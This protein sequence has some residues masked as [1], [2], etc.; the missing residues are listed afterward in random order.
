MRSQLFVTACFAFACTNARPTVNDGGVSAADLELRG[1][2]VRS[3]SGGALRVITTADRLEVFR[4][5]GTRGAVVGLDAGV[6]LASDGTTVHAPFVNGNLLDGHLEATGGVRLQNPRGR[7][8]SSPRMTVERF[9]SGTGVISSDA[10]LI[11]DEPGLHLEA[12][13]FEF[14]LGEE[15]ATFMDARS[16]V[17]T[18]KP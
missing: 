7:T 4:E 16:T 3:Y 13:E 5:V 10:G 17:G 6:W 1:V 14:D 15:R 18:R 9:Q 2:A 8:A 11:L 12:T